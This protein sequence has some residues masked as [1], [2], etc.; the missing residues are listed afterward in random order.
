MSILQAHL[1]LKFHATD[2]GK[3]TFCPGRSKN[4]TVH[5]TLL[6]AHATAGPS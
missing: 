3:S 6:R 1:H 5:G 4:P 2:C